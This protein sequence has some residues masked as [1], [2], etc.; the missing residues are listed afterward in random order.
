[1][2]C[3]RRRPTPVG[4]RTSGSPSCAGRGPCTTSTIP[5]GSRATGP[6]SATPRSSG[7]LISLDA[8][9]HQKMR[10]LVQKGF[11]PRRVATLE[12]RLHGR[13]NAILDSLRDRN[14]CDLVEDIAL[15]LPLH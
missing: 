7:L 12:E 9:D 1:M 14:E 3:T 10:L 11:T 4:S 15:W 2:S 13:V 8:P 5:R 6:S